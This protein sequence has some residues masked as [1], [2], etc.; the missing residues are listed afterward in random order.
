MLEEVAA[1]QPVTVA[2]IARAL[3]LPKT[4]VQRNLITLGE[5]GWLTQ[6]NGDRSWSLSPKMAVLANRAV[7]EFTLRE[8]A[9]EPMRRLRDATNESVLL[10]ERRG[11]SAVVIDVAATGQIVRAVATIGTLLPLHASAG[12]KAI[13]AA[14]HG[15]RDQALRTPL[16]KFT[17][18]TMIDLADL[19]DE[20]ELARKRGWARQRSEFEGGVNSAAAAIPRYDGKI[21]SAAVVLF[22]PA[23]RL[24]DEVIERVAPLVIHAATEIATRLTAP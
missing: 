2:A 18:K 9:A 21:P 10:V 22:G 24:T 3:S 17:D 4:T 19:A 20:V 5:A 23:N 13:L 1:R 16:T 11:G 12:G 7:S 14:G 15:I 8:A 6:S